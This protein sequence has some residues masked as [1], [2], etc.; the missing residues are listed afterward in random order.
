M[1]V[2]TGK[3]GVGESEFQETQDEVFIGNLCRVGKVRVS[4]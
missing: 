2:G 3:R 4:L 1:T